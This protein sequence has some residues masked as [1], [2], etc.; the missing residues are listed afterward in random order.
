MGVLD[1]PRLEAVE[2]GRG[3]RDLPPGGLSLQLRGDHGFVALKR[4]GALHGEIWGGPGEVD[5][6]PLEP[7]D[8]LLS[9]A[10]VQTQHHEGE[11]GGAGDR[12]NE[13][14]LL[15]L[16]ERDLFSGLFPAG[17]DVLRRGAAQ[18]TLPDGGGEHLLEGT[19]DL[20]VK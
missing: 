6:V 18:L 17:A 4:T 1:A 12:L 16:G 3:Q 10:S 5:T 7:Q 2:Q 20:P 19:D 14:R 9:E 11:G 15:A 13:G 8:L